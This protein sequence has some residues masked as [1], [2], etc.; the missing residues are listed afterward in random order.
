MNHHISHA[1]AIAAVTRVH[2]DRSERS[3]RR[4]AKMSGRR[5]AR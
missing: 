2:Q 1:L 4:P 3:L 5:W